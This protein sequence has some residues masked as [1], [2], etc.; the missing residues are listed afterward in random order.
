MFKYLPYVVWICW[1]CLPAQEN[2][3]PTNLQQ[4]QIPQPNSSQMS[5][6]TSSHSQFLQNMKDEELPPEFDP[7]LFPNPDTIVP[8]PATPATEYNFQKN[9]T[10]STATLANPESHRTNLMFYLED[11]YG[12]DNYLIRFLP[13]Y[14]Y[15]RN[16]DLLQDELFFWP[17]LAG[18]EVARNPIPNVMMHCGN[19]QWHCFPFLTLGGSR[20]YATESREVSTMISFLMLT[21]SQE[22]YIKNEYWSRQFYSLPAMSFYHSESVFY[23]NYEFHNTTI[24]TPL[25]FLEDI[26]IKYQDQLYPV[27]EWA[28]HPLSLVLG[29]DSFQIMYHGR[30]GR[31]RRF[32][33]CNFDGFSLLSISTSFAEYPGAE[34]QRFIW[35]QSDTEKGL[36][37]LFAPR[38]AFPTTRLGILYPFLVFETNPDS[39]FAWQ[40]LPLFCYASNQNRFSFQLLPFFLKFDSEG[41]HFNIAPKFFPLV[42]HD[43]RINRWDILWPL[44]YYQK[45]PAFPETRWEFR[46]VASYQ[47]T[48]TVQNESWQKFSLIEGLLLSYHDSDNKKNLE[49]LPGGLLFG[50]YDNESEF[51]WRILGC[52]YEDTP[53]KRSLQI[54]FIKIPLQ[55]KYN[56]QR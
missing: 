51:Q 13:F 41:T 27:Y 6:T 48:M 10:P 32:E 23:K 26:Q 30:W 20:I 54:L 37:Q 42:Y 19:F 29:K 14:T 40:I 4:N 9:P 52:G 39:S 43:E 17:L 8:M 7:K 28:V 46:F 36:Q 56:G 5:P 18:Y 12:E 33:I 53:Q 47:K 55:Y 45:N 31:D 22:T 24:G 1:M 38:I 44:F 2:Y 21:F 49:I 50:F 15:R 11:V 16:R 34:Y 25:F 3:P 35:N